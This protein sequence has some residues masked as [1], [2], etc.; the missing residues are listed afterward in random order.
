[1]RIESNITE[2]ISRFRQHRAEIRQA[3]D[4]TLQPANWIQLARHHAE[5]TL[6]AL[7]Q[8]N[9]R[10]FIE[11]FI[12]AVTAVAFNGLLLSLDAPT[13]SR[14]AAQMNLAGMATGKFSALEIPMADMIEFEQQVLQWVKEKK[15]WDEER[16]GPKNAM[17]ETEKAQWITYIMLAPNLSTVAATPGRMSEQEA[18]DQL[19]P[20]IAEYLQRK[21]NAA[22]LAPE[23]TDLWLRAVLMQWTAMVQS[24]FPNRLRA[25]L[26]QLRQ[27]TQKPLV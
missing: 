20:H 15:R 16:D 23:T 19:L 3:V 12:K 1:M 6:L 22:R 14:V 17:T 5:K 21:T 18:R 25:E 27:R 11:D 13:Y 9:E 24:E 2:V 7:A 26:D 10:Q 4:Q 8:P